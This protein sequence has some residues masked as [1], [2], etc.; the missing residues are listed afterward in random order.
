MTEPIDPYAIPDEHAEIYLAI[1]RMA[2]LLAA[3]PGR[4]FFVAT[5]RYWI[6]GDP[7]ETVGLGVSQSTT[8][9]LIQ[10]QTGFTC[11]AFFAPEMLRPAARPRVET[12]EGVVQVRLEMRMEDIWMISTNFGFGESDVLYQ[13][14]PNYFSD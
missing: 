9:N 10:T 3:D 5:S 12:A 2:E 1:K 6:E 4:E 13:G 7:Y 8:P 11:D 14:V